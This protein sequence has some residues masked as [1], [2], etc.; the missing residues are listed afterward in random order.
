M[1]KNSNEIT[2][3]ILN[4]T[5][6]IISLLTGEVSLPSWLSNMDSAEGDKIVSTEEALKTKQEKKRIKRC[7][8]CAKKVDDNAKRPICSD[9][10]TKIVKDEPHN[11]LQGIREMVREEVQALKE[12]TL[13]AQSGPSWKRARTVTYGISSPEHSEREFSDNSSEVSTPTP[14]GD[15][16]YFFSN[17]DLEELI[18]TVR[19][20]MEVTDTPQVRSVQDEMFWGLRIRHKKCFPVNENLRNMILDEWHKP[21]RGSII[22][23]DFRE[24]LSFTAEDA[25]LCSLVSVS[26]QV[27][28]TKIVDDLGSFSGVLG[29]EI[30]T[31]TMGRHPVS[32]LTVYGEQNTSVGRDQHSI[33][34]GGPSK[35][36]SKSGVGLPE[37][38]KTGSGKLVPQPGNF[39]QA[40]LDKGLSPR[41]L[42]V[43]TA[44]LSALFDV[45]LS[46]NK[47]IRRFLKGADR[48]K[49]FLRGP[50]PSWDLNVVLEGLCNPPFEPINHITDYTIVKKTS[51]DG[52]TP[53][54]H[55][56]ESGG[57]SRSQIP[58][59][60]APPHLPIHEQKILEL[61]NKI[62]ELLTGEVPIRC[63]DVAVYFSMEEWEYL[64]ERKDLYK[65]VKIED[66]QPPISQDNPSKNSDGNF[67]SSLNY[68]VEDVV[69]RSPRE[70]R[71]TLHLQSELNCTDLSCNPPN[72]E[73]PSPDQSQIVITS[74]GHKGGK[75]FQCPKCG[76][77]F[78]KSSGLSAHCRTHR[79]KS[80]SCSECGQRF[81][82]KSHLVRHEK[83]HTGEKKRSY[84]EC[85][86]YF[87]TKAKLKQHQRSHAGEKSYSCSEC[88]KCFLL[89]SNLVKHEKL[90]TG[91]K[92]YSCL[93][94]GKCYKDKS[95]LVQHNRFHTGEKP[96]S[97]TE[98]GNCFGTKSHLV[99]HERTH[100]GEK[101][102]TC[103]ECG[104]C[105]KDKSSLVQHNRFHTGEKPYS[106]S[107]CGN[108]FVIK[109][110]LVRHERT[111]TGAKPYSC[112]ECGN[113]FKD[114]SSL[115]VHHRIHTGEKPYSCSECGKC[116][117]SR[118]SLFTHRKIH[119]GEKPY[120]CS[121][122]GKCFLLKSGLTKHNKIHTGE[123]PFSCSEC[124]KCFKLKF[125]LA[126]HHRLH[127]GEKPYSCSVCRKCFTGK[128]SLLAHQR[129]HTGNKPFS[130]SECG[131]CFT[132]NIK[133]RNH[134]RR[135][136]KLS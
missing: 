118:S 87:I 130:C 24:R 69:Q 11:L 10:A 56:H 103:S 15:K 30:Q 45:K 115:I 134:Q 76:K 29:E 110:H 5:L 67:M 32:S 68:K 128:S 37:Q 88:G 16:K 79:E 55:L 127:T 22:Q 132:S 52:T 49:P 62:T 50:S 66:H 28:I 35:R 104:K 70:N 100:T 125:H 42:R 122:C 126:R 40:E 20:T 12:Q 101:P 64:E 89:K 71:I 18:S 25:S 111:H 102:Y 54:S 1:E 47:W 106:C 114:K 43:Q 31:T 36:D 27:F 63:Q 131:K 41:T 14:E 39:L 77:Q 23:K 84:S 4:F 124:G 93:E 120:S 80:Y 133:C 90:H 123:K 105:Y 75:R 136:H 81:T 44:A 83:I 113:W 58:I 129:I 135:Q 9:C 6:E 99:R 78:K 94:C 7:A 8:L 72:D 26:L 95:S 107:E 74:A 59:T 97:C 92:P 65:D 2:K 117:K 86:K 82:S 116:F 85:G 91:E 38:K 57:W 53:N 109:S 13:D 19:N 21:K 119:T 121:E 34:L 33:P 61:T 46:E 73:G 51:G 3:R 108:C 48:S 98:C 96:Y 17:L 60:E 112:S